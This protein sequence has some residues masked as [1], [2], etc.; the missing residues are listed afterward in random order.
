MELDFYDAC[1]HSRRA[2]LIILMYLNVDIRNF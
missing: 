1:S 2:E